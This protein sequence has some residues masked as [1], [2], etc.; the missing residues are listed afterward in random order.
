MDCDRA[1]LSLVDNRN[2]FICAEMTK[3]QSL[4]RPDPAQPLLLGV[5]SIALDWGVCPYTVSVFHGK[6]VDL[7]DTPYI[8]ADPS[9]F[10]IKDFRKVPS[11]ATRPYVA[12]YPNMVSYVEVPLRSLSGHILGSYCV[13]DNRSRDFLQPESLATIREVTSSINA[14]LNMKR[15][16][17]GRVRSE[18]VVEGLRQ[19]I[20]SERH[21]PP[22]RADETGKLA[23]GPFALDVFSQT[24]QTGYVSCGGQNVGSDGALD[25]SGMQC[26]SNPTDSALEPWYSTICH[27]NSTLTQ[28]VDC[29]VDFVC[30][31]RAKYTRVNICLC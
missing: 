30:Y 25:V 2:Q 24:R 8:V 12:D 22:K 16:D 19:F 10:Y 15:A 3:H 1:F 26:T 23:T 27:L 4:A 17:A 18:R 9:Y 31:D 21:V 20:G 13:V 7:P 11:F 28:Y 6:K 29:Y 5:A 14:Y